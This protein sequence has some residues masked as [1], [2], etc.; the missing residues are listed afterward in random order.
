MESKGGVMEIIVLSDIHGDLGLLELAAEGLKNADLVMLSGDITHFGK[1][2]QVKSLI[3]KIKV[4]NP[5]IVG[6]PGNC[7]YSDVNQYL[8][9]EEMSLDCRYF[10][11]GGL[12]F[13]GVGGSLPCP[14]RTPNEY[15][16]EDF[17][18]M[19]EKTV[20]ANKKGLPIV[21]LLHQP[22]FNTRLDQLSDG[23]HLGSHSIRLFIEKFQP[24]LCFSG[25]I[26]EAD[27]ID[28]IG[29]TTLVNPGPFKMGKYTRAVVDGNIAK[30]EIID[31]FAQ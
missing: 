8:V 12:F 13:M 15:H 19:L 1:A 10:V 25:H 20:E 16:E 22:P 7:D 4:Y 30:A 31:M 26:H 11:H 24:L 3:D 9:S 6:V 29:K 27:G 14:G 28:H 23:F 21:L 2:I 5:N 18:V 17:T